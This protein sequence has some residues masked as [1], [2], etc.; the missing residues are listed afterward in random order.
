[1][2]RINLEDF[3]EGTLSQ[4]INRAIQQIANNIQDPN[5]DA[6]KKRKLTTTITFSPDN[7]RELVIANI[8]TKTTLAPTIAVST[9]LN[10]GI[11]LMTGKAEYVEIGKQ[12][13]GQMQLAD[14]EER[15][16]DTETGEIME[17]ETEEANTGKVIDLR[18][19]QA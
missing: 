12:I 18:S 1:M 4:Q 14:Y 16:V 2:K 6:T 17:Q 13:P 8:E 5:T 7:K 19:K 15:K 3:A 11:N 9:S 10:M